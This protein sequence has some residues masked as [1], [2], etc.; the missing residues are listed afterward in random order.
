M[1]FQLLTIAV[2][3]AAA[4]ACRDYERARD[5]TGAEIFCEPHVGTGHACPSNT[6]CGQDSF[7]CDLSRPITTT[8]TRRTT[9][10]TRRSCPYGYARDHTGAR[11]YCEPHV[12]SG[13][14]CP[15]GSTCGDEFW[16]CNDAAVPTTRG[17]TTT[18][19]RSTTTTA[20]FGCRRG[21]ARDHTGAD[22]YC[23]RDGYACTKS[24]YCGPSNFCCNY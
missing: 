15:S 18:T 1:K 20:R 19:L 8:T 21:V 24:S 7:C 12:G 17:P 4:A 14:A 3:V 11:V 16:C 6:F 13:H 10:T 5:H 2:L 9:T 22:I 23:A